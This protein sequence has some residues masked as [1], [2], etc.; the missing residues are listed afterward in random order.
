MPSPEEERIER[1]RELKHRYRE[2]Y[3]ELAAILFRHDPVRINFEVNP[4]EYEIEVD[5]ILPRLK[6][7]SSWQQVNEVVHEEF[8]RWFGPETAGP[9][10]RYQTIAE[11]IWHAWQRK[12]G[13]RCSLS[14]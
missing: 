10:E 2:L 4:K 13:P 5:T 9:S 1:R 7:C 14:Y 3:D 6:A 8:V 11:E 12:S